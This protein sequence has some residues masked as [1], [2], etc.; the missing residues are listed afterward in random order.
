M[1]NV[2]I[3]HKIITDDCRQCNNCTAINVDCQAITKPKYGKVVIDGTLCNYCGKCTEQCKR[4]VIKVLS[5]NSGNK[6]KWLNIEPEK[7]KYSWLNMPSGNLRIAITDECNMKCYYCHA[8][9][10]HE[11]GEL[12]ASDI[13]RIIEGSMK[14]GLKDVRF[15]GGEPVLHHELVSVCKYLNERY[16]ILNLGIN[17]NCV[18][19]DKIMRLITETKISEIAAGVDY[20]DRSI[21]K[22]SSLGLPSKHILENVLRIFEVVPNTSITM[23]YDGDLDNV[24]KMIEW[25][26]KHKIF[27]KILEKIDGEVAPLP[28]EKYQEMAKAV[29]RKFNMQ[30]QYNGTKQRYFGVIRDGGKKGGGVYFFTSHCRM[31]ECVLC[32][33]RYFKVDNKGMTQSCLFGGTPQFSLMDNDN[34]DNNFKA[35]LSYIATPPENFNKG[36]LVW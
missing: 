17:T 16:L 22:Q 11:K 25:C 8:E 27:L 20:A 29:I 35:A 15:T 34:F 3:K 21:S 36:D 12:P 31:R 28:T 19:I 23:V 14:Y 9:G 7:T 6:H 4:K 18:D 26:K 2:S 24:F 10:M 1:S 30:L 13:I 32:R 5:F 33:E